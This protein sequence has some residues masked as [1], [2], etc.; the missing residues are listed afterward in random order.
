VATRGIRPNPT[1]LRLLNST[2]RRNRHGDPDEARD[3]IEAETQDF[4]PLIRP[5]G[6]S[7][8]A[9]AC[10]KDMIEPARW[11]DGS[12]RVA[13]QAFCELYAEW[14]LG[15]HHFPG[16]KHAQM[17]AYMADLGL[18]DERNRIKTNKKVK[19][20]FFDD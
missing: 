19:D 10:W 8:E 5:K 1:V 16:A 6:L 4:G 7:R 13:A 3:K 14:V 15:P 20:E 17:R 18:A 11:L 12:K 9:I 2:H